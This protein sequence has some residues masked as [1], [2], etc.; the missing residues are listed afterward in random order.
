MTMEDPIEF[1]HRDRNCFVTQR[2]IGSDC[3]SFGTLRRALRHDPDVIM[4]GELRD[5]E[6]ISLA[7]TAAET[8]HL[9]LATVHTPGAIQTVDRILDA[10]PPEERTEA[11]GRVASC[12]QGVLSQTLVPRTTGGRV[13]VVEV[14]VSTEAVRSCIREGKTHQIHSQI[15]TGMQHG[16]QTCAT[17]LADLVHKS[18]ITEEVAL[19]HAANLDE[20]KNQLSHGPSYLRSTARPAAHRLPAPPRRARLP[21]PGRPLPSPAPAA[22][23]LGAPAQFRRRRAAQKLRRA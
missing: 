7:L 5:R 19:Q 4:I 11:R 17:A 15:Q 21:G 14:M 8:G 6:T 9:V 23:V 3:E 13:A 12:L 2:E 1:V 10:F 20:L 18:M 22:P 16:M